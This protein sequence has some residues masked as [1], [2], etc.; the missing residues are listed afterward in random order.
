MAITPLNG[1]LTAG[2][3]G[4]Y[5]ETVNASPEPLLTGDVPALMA[6]TELVLTSQ[7]LAA[8]TVVGLNAAGKVVPALIGSVDPA[9]DIPAIGILAYATDT[10][11]ADAFGEVYRM[12]CFNPNLLVWPASY[13]TDE[14]KRNAF[15]GA[16]SPTAIVI[17]KPFAATA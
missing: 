1:D 9:N 15:E 17:R 8:L 2:I 6:K 12:G 13:N 16:P 7:T 11:G 14:K 3:A 5:T 4:S 10:T